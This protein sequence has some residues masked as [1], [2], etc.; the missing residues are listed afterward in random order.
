MLSG[1]GIALGAPWVPCA[2][3]CAALVAVS[4]SRP[5]CSAADEWCACWWADLGLGVVEALE[6]GGD[7][8]LEQ[9]EGGVHSSQ[10]HVIRLAEMT[11][12]FVCRLSAPEDRRGVFWLPWPFRLRGRA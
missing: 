2:E 6:G 9:V 5:W 8:A 11:A 3:G 12:N 7:L 10:D 4:R 1:S